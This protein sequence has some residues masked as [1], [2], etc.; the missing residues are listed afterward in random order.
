MVSVADPSDSGGGEKSWFKRFVGLFRWFSSQKTPFVDRRQYPRIRTANLIKI[1]KLDSEEVSSL[2]NLV[3]ISEGGIQM[4][5]PRRIPAQ[6]HFWAVLN[7]AE[8]DTQIPVEGRVV[9]SKKSEKGNASYRAGVEFTDLGDE[10]R[11]VIRKY[12]EDTLSVLW[13]NA[14]SSLKAAG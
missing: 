2:S 11:T 12:V 8:K 9:W 13:L 10:G 7:L 6:A 3:N 1:L 14:R 5:S 4:M